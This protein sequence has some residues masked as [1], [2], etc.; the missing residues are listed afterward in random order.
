MKVFFIRHGKD[1][2]RYRGGWSDLDLIPEG[3]QQAKLL[4]DH[5]KENNHEYRI[6]KIIS[7]DLPRTMSTA[8]FI[9]DALN[10][11]VQEEPRLREI[12]NGDLA[13]MLNNEALEQYP[14]LFFRSLKMNE[15][16]PNGESPDDF[17][18]RIKKWFNEFKEQYKNTYE[19]IL[20]VTHGGVINI[21]YHL[22]NGIEWNNKSTVVK[23]VNCGIHILNM[24]TMKFEVENSTDFLTNSTD[25]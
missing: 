25:Y 1:D 14:G 9:S 18:L 15:P 24:D 2:D 6:G 16:Y 21:F 22:V 23:T 8:Q 4:A 3:R 5:L 20:V 12:N 19:N 11:P 7:S 17:F 13:G 10:L